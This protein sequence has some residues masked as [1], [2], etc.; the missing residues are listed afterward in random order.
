MNGE[1]CS[2]HICLPIKAA[3]S[4]FRGALAESGLLVRAAVWQAWIMR[5]A[6][7]RQCLVRQSIVQAIFADD[8][9]GGGAI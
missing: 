5:K 2:Q 7:A 4:Y 9:L 8:W 1:L 3:V 6:I